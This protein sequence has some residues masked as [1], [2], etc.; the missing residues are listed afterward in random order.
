ML[1]ASSYG[2][3][4]V[5]EIV[6]EV[7]TGSSTIQAYATID[8]LPVSPS[9]KVRFAGIPHAPVQGNRVAILGTSL[10]Q[11]NFAANS[12]FK[13]SSWSKGWLSWYQVFNPGTILC[14]VWWDATVYPGWEPS[15]AGTTIYYRGLNAGVGGAELSQIADRAEFLVHNINCDV[16]IFEGGTNDIPNYSAEYIHGLREEICDY[17]LSKGK[18]VIMT[19]ILS[20]GISSWASGSDRRK[21]A[22]YVNRLTRDY[23]NSRKNCFLWDWNKQWVDFNST[24]GV[25]KAGYS[26]D[27]THLSTV[28]AFVQ[29]QDL[30]LILNQIFPPVARSVTSPED[31]YDAT[32][33]PRGNKMLNPVLTGTSGTTS[34][35]V[36]GSTATSMRTLRSSGAGGCVASKEVRADGRGNWQVLTLSTTAAAGTNLFY[37]QTSTTDIA[38]GL[39]AGTWVKASV[40]VDVSAWAGWK[41]VTLHLRD[42]ATGG[43]ISYGMEDYGD[44]WPS[45]AWSGLIETPAIQL[46]DG[47][48][49]LRW[50]VEIKTDNAI[51]GTGVIKLGSVEL[52]AVK[53][54]KEIVEYVDG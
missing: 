48:S 33:N 15:G 47:A 36:T 4:E 39:S 11:H 23:V 10:V 19:T 32:Y 24:D 28:A 27:D 21:K 41:G 22:A 17:L 20:R 52:R 13:L 44:V 1:S 6:A 7:G 37:L 26:P 50:R 40:E 18:T 42:N 45:T 31:L 35:P 25:P 5:G 2:V 43:I 30:G 12:G 49:T 54:P 8:R 16:V 3:N 34:A 53:S 29:A 51:S 9:G 46:M 14:P 38:H